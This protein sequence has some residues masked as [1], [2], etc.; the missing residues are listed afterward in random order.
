MIKVRSAWPLHGTRALTLSGA[1]V[2]DLLC[3][4][5]WNRLATLMIANVENPSRHPTRALLDFWTQIWSLKKDQEAANKK[6]PKTSAAQLRVQK[7]G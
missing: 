3:L 2:P 5:V 7:G 4:L 6:K 1:H